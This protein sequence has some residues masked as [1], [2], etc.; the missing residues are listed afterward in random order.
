[1]QFPAA[2]INTFVNGHLVYGNEG[3]DESQKGKRLAFQR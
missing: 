1:M 3:F 2:I